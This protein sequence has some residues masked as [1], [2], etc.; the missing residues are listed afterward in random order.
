MGDGPYYVFLRPY[1]LCHFE[2]PWTIREIMNNKKPILV[3]KKRLLEVGT[4]AKKDLEKGTELDG[5]GGF[6]TYGVLET[7]KSFPIGLSDDVVLT[8]RKRK[9]EPIYWEDIEFPKND[10]RIDLWDKQGD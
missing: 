4:R 6:D 3:Q 9:D 1:H 8:K 10:P 7:P 2:T 5:I